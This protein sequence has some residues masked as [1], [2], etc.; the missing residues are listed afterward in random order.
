VTFTAGTAP[1]TTF[2]ATAQIRY[3]AAPVPVEVT[4]L[5]NERAEVAFVT[6]QRS[7]TPGQSLVFYEGDVVLGGGFIEP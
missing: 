1:S 3:R 2:N 6:P 5:D 4:L 7:V